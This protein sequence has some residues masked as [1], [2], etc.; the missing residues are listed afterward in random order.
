M[1]QS[2]QE[3]DII[4]CEDTRITGMLIKLLQKKQINEQLNEMSEQQL[5]EFR[6]DLELNE[7]EKEIQQKLQK[8]EV[9]EET[10]TK[11]QKIARWKQR[12]DLEREQRIE[13][14]K[15]KAKRLLEDEDTLK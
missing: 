2:I 10:L 13:E 7:K 3:A 9:D 4:A 15:K 8:I 11:E 14:L 1:Y 5:Q 12:L 6:E